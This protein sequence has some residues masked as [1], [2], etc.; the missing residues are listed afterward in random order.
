M[1]LYW[2]IHRSHVLA[3]Y[4]VLGVLLSLLCQRNR[5]S[6]DGAEPL[7]GLL[8]DLPPLCDHRAPDAGPNDLQVVLEDLIHLGCRE[9]IS[10]V[11]PRGDLLLEEDPVR[12]EWILGVGD[13]GFDESSVRDE[14]GCGRS[15]SPEGA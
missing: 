15:G 14:Y 5:S 13:E 10:T 12:D 7:A 1:I 2:F 3:L 6:S 8:S 9:G 11:L 4:E